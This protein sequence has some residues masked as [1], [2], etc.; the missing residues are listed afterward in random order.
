MPNNILLFPPGAF[1]GGG[2]AGGASIIDFLLYV[3]PTRGS[4]AGTGSIDSPFA[5]IAQAAA[6]I[7]AHANN[8]ATWA[9]ER[10]TV[11]A[12]GGRYTEAGPIILRQ[13]RRSMRLYGQGAVIENEVR[14]V[15]DIADYPDAALFSPLL[16]PTPWG[17]PV[18]AIPVV[19]FELEGE[20]GGMEGG[21]P[22][23]NLTLLGLASYHAVSPQIAAFDPIFWWG[24]R[25]Q[26][27]GGWQFTNLSGVAIFLTT[28]IDSSSI[29][30]NHIGSDGAAGANMQLKAS[31]SQLRGTIG[32]FCNILEID[33][34]RVEAVDRTTDFAGAPVAGNVTSSSAV[35]SQSFISNCAFPGVV[36]NFGA[37]GPGGV[38]ILDET[39]FN[40]L[41]VQPGV[42]L[43][44]GNSFVISDVLRGPTLSRPTALAPQGTRYYDTTL[45]IPIWREP[46]AG[47]GWINAAGVA[48]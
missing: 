3:S 39:S 29:I 41:V 47:T 33:A 25:I 14:F 38:I 13:V 28:E 4:A 9:N 44:A 46:A 35:A 17:P 2:G 42:T 31:N 26:S 30:N 19:C 23:N 18:N 34:C 32:P 20:G 11:Y 45:L 5:T 21:L 12:E 10:Y 7:P 43:T 15:N 27:F 48:V 36:Y 37:A 1:G 6:A 16:V 8:Y 40:R 24:H 22:A